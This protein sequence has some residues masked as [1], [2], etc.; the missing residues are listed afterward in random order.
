MSI[1]AGDSTVTWEIDAGGV[2]S[3]VEWKVQEADSAAFADVHKAFYE[4]VSD[5][6]TVTPGPTPPKTPGALPESE[7]DSH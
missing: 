4:D 1:F 2:A 3:I 5:R 7:S 6:P